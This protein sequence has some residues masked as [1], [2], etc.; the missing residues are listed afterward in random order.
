MR[1]RSHGRDGRGEREKEGG[2][3]GEIGGGREEEKRQENIEKRKEKLE[4]LRTLIPLAKEGNTARG[5]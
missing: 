2:G 1:D 5:C 3:G 4:R